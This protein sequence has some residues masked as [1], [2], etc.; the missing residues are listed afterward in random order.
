LSQQCPVLTIL[1][2]TLGEHA[3]SFVTIKNRVAQFKR[4]D[5]STCDEPHPGQPKTVPTLEK[6]DQ[7]H[8][9]I[10]EDRQ[11]SPKSIAEQLGSSRERGWVNHSR[12][13]GHV[14]ALHKVGPKM[15]EHRSKTS[16][17]PVI[18][19]TFGNFWRDS[20]DLL[21]RLVTTDKTRLYYYDPET[22]QQSMDWQHSGPPRPKK[23]LTAKICC[24][25]SCLDFLGSRQHPPCWLSSKGLNYQHGV[26]LIS[27]GAYEGHFEGKTPAAGRSQRGS[28]SCTTMPRLMGHLQP[29]RNWPTWASNVLFTHPIL[30]SWPRR[31]TTCSLDW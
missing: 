27:A 5:F 1:I 6:I 23:I 26:L 11:I 15:P 17:V 22:K 31:T 29:R 19:A 20:N 3:P 9:L 7:I 12:R 16:T 4:R 30:L 28:C 25:S 14:E 13:I 8:K 2:K 21:S 24:K 10:L 18:W